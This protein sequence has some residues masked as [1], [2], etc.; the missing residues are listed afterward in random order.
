MIV[1]KGYKCRIYPTAKQKLIISSMFGNSRFVYNYCLEHRQRIFKEDGRNVSQFE[2]MREITRLRSQEDTKWLSDGD[3]M[4][5]QEAVKD[6][7]KAYQNFFRKNN[8]FPKFHSKRGKQSYRTRNQ[9]NGI[10]LEGNT[11]R[12]PKVGYVKYK[13]LKPFAGRILN[14]TVSLSNSGKYYISLCV[15]E[16]TVLKGN[17]GG[18]IGIDVGISEFY[19]D[20]NGNRIDNPQTLNS[21]LK[22]LIRAQ[23]RLSRKEKGSSNRH[24][25]KIR[26]AV[27]HEKI[28]NIRKDFLHKQSRM[29]TS[30]NQ[31]VCI[32]DLNVKGMMKNHYLARNISDVSWSEFF[33]MIQY[34]SEE[35]GCTIIRVP[36]FYP[37]SQTCSN[38]GYQNTKLRNLSIREWDCP[39]CGMHHDRDH[40][41]A[42]NILRKGL[43][44]M[45]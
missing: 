5:L 32:E 37:S 21:H 9:D 17:N 44:M 31:V 6:L 4:A 14:A 16:E 30:E 13:G 1:Q 42:I 11:V 18:K 2:L 19:S 27:I 12:I 34:K 33:R 26:L 36:T 7:N 39:E 15:E 41:A 29:L 43:E 35:H 38:C 10:R 25:Q 8:R 20:S 23:R 45:S 40:N 3:S 28:A 24:K 22:K